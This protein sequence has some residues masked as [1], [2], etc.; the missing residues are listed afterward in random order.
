MKSPTIHVSLLALLLSF[1]CS[2]PPGSTTASTTG[3]AATAAGASVAV[4][5]S[6]KR[7]DE[8]DW[9]VASRTKFAD[10]KQAF[11]TVRDTLLKSY[12]AD[13]ITEDDVYRAAAQ[14]MLERLEPKLHKWNKLISPEELAEMHT[15]LKGEIVGIGVKIEF[16]KD[17]GYTAVKGVVP[18]TPAEKVGLLAGDTIVRV[19]GKLYKGLAESDVVNDMRGKVGETVTLSVLRDGKLLSV[20]VV[21][22]VV[23]FDAVI[24]SALPGGVGYVRIPS[25]TTKTGPA[26]KAALDDLAGKSVHGLV[27]DLRDNHG[28]GFEDAV[29]SAELFLPAGAPIATVVK[30]DH[31]EDSYTSKN[32]APVLVSVPMAV[33]ADHDTSSGAEL[34]TAALQEGRHAVVVGQRTYGKWTVQ[35]LDELSNGYGFKYTVGLFRSPGGRSFEGAGLTPDVEVDM[36]PKDVQKCEFITEPEKRLAADVQLRTA[37]TLLG[38]KP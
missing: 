18:G 15:S 33:L 10:G 3:A 21:R 23:T 36:D 24:E 26:L 35:H 14:G 32:P 27:L 30:R 28:G 25:F 31:K 19:N 1:G 6:P 13:G 16:D 11:E 12:Y 20:P 4:E 22:Q 17:T 8:E 38:A 2:Q 9:G 29:A 37:A 5:S 34:I 7:A